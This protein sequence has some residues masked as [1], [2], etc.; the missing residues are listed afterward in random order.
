VWLKEEGDSEDR[1]SQR[2]TCGGRWILKD[3]RYGTVKILLAYEPVRSQSIG[4]ELYRNYKRHIV[5]IVG[6]NECGL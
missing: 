1:K 3:V 4:N 6:M 5:F 2:A